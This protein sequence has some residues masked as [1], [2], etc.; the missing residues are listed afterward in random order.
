MYIGGPKNLG[1]HGPPLGTGAWL[2]PRNTLLYMCY[3]AKFHR[4]RSNRLGVGRIPKIGGRHGAPLLG[5]LAWLTPRGMLLNPCYMPNS[6]IL[7]QT[8]RV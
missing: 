5:M 3:H 2:T 6:V 7:D 1:M 8:I 4:S